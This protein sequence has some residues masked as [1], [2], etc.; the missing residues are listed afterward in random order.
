MSEL[1]LGLMSGTSLDGVDAVL[2]DFGP[3]TC[4]LHAAATTPFPDP[5]L[6][7][8]RNLIDDPNCSLEQLGGLNV[9]V[10]AF[11]ARC[12]LRL[13]A[14]S[15]REPVEIRAIGHP[16]HTVF[17]KPNKPEPFTMQIGDP[18]V[19]A[20]ET[21]LTTVADFRSTDVA[22]GGQGA[23]LVPAFHDWCFASADEL[24]VIV[25]LGGIANLTLLDPARPLL[26]FDSG[27][28]NTLLD[29][30]CRHCR[31]KPFDRN[32]DWART[33][34]VN[35]SLL[36]C[37]RDDSYFNRK[38]PKSTGPEHF[39]LSWLRKGIQAMA[40]TIPEHDVQA[41]LA[42]L[43][44]T[45]VADAVKAVAPND[46]RII[47]CGGG[48]YNTALMERLGVLLA[49]TAMESSAVHGIAPEWVEAVAFAWLA[50]ARL[51][52][53][54]GNAPGVTGARQRAVLGAVYPGLRRA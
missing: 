16:G 18:A 40:R 29:A 34:T 52:D 43:T 27:P 37:L 33:G 42:E 51:N 14:E 23:P 41:T 11:F 10:G 35:K 1:Y 6:S 48:T 26:G 25:N 54:P 50:Q 3:N 2:V 4:T 13:V 7:R 22:L 17:H 39:N 5:L 46:K 15:G 20:T 9:A 30:W 31:D 53:K 21:G 24:R 44:A 38:P 28:G 36:K 49:D 45:T 19:V 12:A 47:L 32:G 8:L